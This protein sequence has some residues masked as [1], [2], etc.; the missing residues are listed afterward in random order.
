[1]KETRTSS[2]LNREKKSASMCVNKIVCTSLTTFQNTTI[3]ASPVIWD[4]N[5]KENDE[6]KIFF[7]AYFSFPLIPKS[8]KSMVPMEH[9]LRSEI[10]QGNKRPNRIVNRSVHDSLGERSSSCVGISAS[11]T[12]TRLRMLKTLL[13]TLVFCRSPTPSVALLGV[14][15]RSIVGTRVILPHDDDNDGHQHHQHHQTFN[16]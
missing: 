13:A 11:S 7:P 3:L 14:V 5:E 9:R 16:L 2:R 4:I 15:L 10:P 8:P 6:S 12:S 1:M